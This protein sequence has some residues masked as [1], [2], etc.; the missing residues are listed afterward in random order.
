MSRR[1][2]VLIGSVFA[3][4]Y[5]LAVVEEHRQEKK[6][7]EILNEE[8]DRW[9]YYE[10]PDLARHVVAVFA[11]VAAFALFIGLVVNAVASFDWSQTTLF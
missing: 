5:V 11:A 7:R 6:A 3:L 1:R 4:V 9:L 2:G 10:E 8:N